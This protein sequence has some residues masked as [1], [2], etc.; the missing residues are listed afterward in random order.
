MSAHWK[1][2]YELQSEMIWSSRQEVWALSELWVVS[3]ELRPWKSYR[4]WLKES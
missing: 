3:N 2:N 4:E 1:I